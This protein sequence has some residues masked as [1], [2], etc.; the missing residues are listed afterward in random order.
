MI[1]LPR[2]GLG[3]GP[4]GGLFEP[5]D[6]D[7]AKATVEAAWN[8]RVRLFDTAPLYGSGLAEERLGA[9]LRGYPRDEL[10]LSTK[11]GRLLRP[12]EPD[13]N[14]PGAPPLAPVF[15]YSYDGALRSLE[16]SLERLGLD[17]VDIAL[18]HD[19]QDHVDEA[20]AGAC[21][22]LVR[23]REEGTIRAV[24][25]GLN[26][27]E[28]LLRF[29][30]EADVDCLLVAG[31]Y[32]LLDRQAVPELLPLC[33]E[34]GIAVIAAGVLNSGLLAGGTTFDYAPAPAELVARARELEAICAPYGVPLAAAAVQFP[35]RHPAVAAALIG[36]RSPDELEHDLD[37]AE[38]PIPDELWVALGA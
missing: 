8:R 17:R 11:V 23:L 28:P 34:R 12:G 21:R 18:V 16:E 27:V 13:P 4:L 37:F 6:D 20:L 36:A 7:Q 24:G 22:A 29:A 25:I 5:V 2:I 19:P 15:D 32:T 3:T 30:R 10:L 14:F 1:A 9:V 38:L 33:A 31:R 26:Y 35:L